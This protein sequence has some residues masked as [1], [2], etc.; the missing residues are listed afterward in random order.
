MASRA[1]AEPRP[2]ASTE[3]TFNKDDHETSP[4]SGIVGNK[5]ASQDTSIEAA[6]WQGV[7]QN[8]F[9]VFGK[10]ESADSE[11]AYLHTL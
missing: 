3:Q 7:A 4:M 2:S 1:F 5:Q 10:E 11:S 8:D 9:D 6:Q